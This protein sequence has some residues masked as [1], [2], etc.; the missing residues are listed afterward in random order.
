MTGTNH[1]QAFL[2]LLQTEIVPSI[3]CT[4]PVAIAFAAALARRSFHALPER[5]H[6]RVSASLYKNARKAVVPHTEGLS[7][8][9]AAAVAGLVGGRSELG[10][11]VLETIGESHLE[12]IR[13]YLETP[14]CAVEVDS[15]DADFSCIVTL[16]SGARNAFVVL[17]GSHTNVER[18]EV[19]GVVLPTERLADP[20]V[21]RRSDVFRDVAF[22]DLYEFAKTVS[23]ERIEPIVKPQA[24]ANMNIARV[25]LERTEGA[26]LGTL[27]PTLDPSLLGRMK[28]ATAAAIEARMAGA[29]L[30]VYINSGSGNQ[31]I[32]ASVPIVVYAAESAIP[33]ERLMRALVFSNLVALYQKAQVGTL[34]AYCGA[35]GA[36]AASAC[37][38]VLMNGG[39]CDEAAAVLEDTLAI[40]AGLVCDGAKASCGA[41]AALAL[42]AAAVSAALVRRKGTFESSEGII[43]P[44]VEDTVGTVGRIAREGMAD[45]DKVLVD[46]MCSRDGIRFR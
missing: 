22:R 26:R 21:G 11:R 19:D 7:G 1:E 31:G 28:A 44:S 29:P 39:T 41:K 42:E 45:V 17:R 12:F 33:R 35:V 24:E 8:V 16:W 4:E 20:I 3:G 18:I 10:L 15:A 32:S 14:F 46:A 9:A 6:V 43:G 2:E 40:T 36:V 25:G 37:G 27:Y 23:L 30:P 5:M 13:K 38:I 34:S